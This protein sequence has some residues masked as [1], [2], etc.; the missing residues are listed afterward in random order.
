MLFI[1]LSTKFPTPISYARAVVT[2]TLSPIFSM[3]NKPSEWTDD[4]IDWL[5]IYIKTAEQNKELMAENRA[6]KIWQKEVAILDDENKQLRSLLDVSS[7]YVGEPIAVRILTDSSSPFVR[8]VLIGAGRNKGISEG[9]EVVHE[10]GLVGRVVEVFPN[11]SRVLLITDYS[12]RI[13][14][15]I[16]ANRV[17]GLARGTNN[18]NLEL[19]LV[20]RDVAVGPGSKVVTSGSNGLLTPN[21][22]VGTLTMEGERVLIRPYVDLNTLDFVTVQRRKVEGILADGTN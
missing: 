17:R 18:N 3:L 15:R 21:I 7:N 5:A 8:S 19:M 16:V 13:P 6:L 14:V 11:T 20:E 2:E 22:P 1:L 12:F 10:N 9:Q 4:G